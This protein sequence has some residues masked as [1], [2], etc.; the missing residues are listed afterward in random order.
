MLMGCYWEESN[1][2]FMHFAN[3]NAGSMLPSQTPER[4]AI[5]CDNPNTGWIFRKL[6]S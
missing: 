5:F 1:N 4:C 3:E 2:E 6:Y